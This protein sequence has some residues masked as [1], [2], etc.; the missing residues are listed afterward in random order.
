MGRFVAACTQIFC[1][2]K[3]IPWSNHLQVLYVLLEWVPGASLNLAELVKVVLVKLVLAKVVLA[4]LVALVQ[5]L[6]S[7]PSGHFTLNFTLWS[8]DSLQVKNA[9]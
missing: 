7:A 5:A 4:E 3:V 2:M 1:F 6:W 9:E 8:L